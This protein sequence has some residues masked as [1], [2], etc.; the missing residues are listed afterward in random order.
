[1]ADKADSV[2]GMRTGFANVSVILTSMLLEIIFPLDSF[3]IIDMYS[4]GSEL[5][6]GGV[7]GGLIGGN[8]SFYAFKKQDP[9]YSLSP[10]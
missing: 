2:L 1:M 10:C 9:M 7:V 3:N 4:R 6:G 5:L 8:F